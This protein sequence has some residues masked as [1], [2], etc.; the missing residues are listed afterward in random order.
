MKNLN[1]LVVLAIVLIAIWLLA[2]V[3]KF[4]AGALLNLLLVAAVVLLLVWGVR[5][6][7]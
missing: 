6:V 3:T 1:L 5:K 4:I 7:L 2:S